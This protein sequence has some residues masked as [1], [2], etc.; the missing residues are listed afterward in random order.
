M[1]AGRDV[2][3]LS[4]HLDD[5]WLSAFALLTSEASVQVW[6]VFAGEPD[7]PQST[8]WDARCGFPDSRSTMRARRAEDVAAF[9]DS[10]VV[11]RHLPLLDAAYR[12]PQTGRRQAHQLRSE[13]Q[14]WVDT[15][16]HGAIALP[17]CA[18]VQV[19]PALWQGI[20]DRWR[21][22]LPDD[23][24]AP[25]GP[26][27][28]PPVARRGPRAFAT[29][30]VRRVLHADHQRRR[31]AAQRRGMA[32][33]PDHLLVRDIGLEVA[34]QQPGVDVVFWEDLPYLWHDRGERQAGRIAR[35][36]QIA[37]EERTIP[38]DPA[39][40]FDRLRHYQSQLDLLD[41]QHH[42]LS[43]PG[44]LPTDETYWILTRTERP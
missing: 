24:P 9:A 6:T 8:A 38:I 5:A 33:N 16:P 39:A 3:V 35:T 7:P 42:R 11:V 18:G 4:P 12:D 44:L 41:P 21:P 13:L 19:K 10:A 40:K 14:G 28:S 20:L 15:H 2:V 22:T 34:L 30:A 29:D 37:L 32:V 43:R 17:V 31:R 26:R 25:D 1:A 27:P 36:H 23:D